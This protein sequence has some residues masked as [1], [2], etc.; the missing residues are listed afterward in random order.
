MVSTTKDKVKSDMVA[1]TKD[2]SQITAELKL[3]KIQLLDLKQSFRSVLSDQEPSDQYIT[4]FQCL[5]LLENVQIGMLTFKQ[6]Y[7]WG[8]KA[9]VFLRCISLDIQLTFWDG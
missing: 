7:V 8:K 3:E 5:S 4:P 1:T 2:K 9:K 6:Y